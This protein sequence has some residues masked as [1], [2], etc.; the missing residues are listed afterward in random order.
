[1]KTSTR[2]QSIPIK[3]TAGAAQAIAI[4]HHRLALVT[5]VGG[6][7]LAPENRPES[8]ARVALKAETLGDFLL[9]PER[10]SA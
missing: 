6:P 7:E 10:L 5:E 1:L 2:Q 9:R 3:W 4:R 8:G